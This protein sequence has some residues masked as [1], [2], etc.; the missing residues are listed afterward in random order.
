MSDEHFI[1]NYTLRL[2]ENNGASMR[3]YKSFVQSQPAGVLHFDF[4]RYRLPLRDDR[5]NTLLLLLAPGLSRTNTIPG[6]LTNRPLP[7]SN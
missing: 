1:Y 7:V 5:Q 6:T 4:Y 2:Q 3:L